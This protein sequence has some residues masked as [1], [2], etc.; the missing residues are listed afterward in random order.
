MEARAIG[1][2][3]AEPAAGAEGGGQ[4]AGLSPRSGK[5]AGRSILIPVDVTHGGAALTQRMGFL[6]WTEQNLQ[7]WVLLVLLEAFVPI[8]LWVLL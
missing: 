6:L 5:P 3:R 4:R 2:P 8:W 1:M 7:S